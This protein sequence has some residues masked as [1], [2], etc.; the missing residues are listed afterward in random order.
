MKEEERWQKISRLYHA[1]LA[2]PEKDIPE[3]AT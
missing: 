2:L 3:L 1:A